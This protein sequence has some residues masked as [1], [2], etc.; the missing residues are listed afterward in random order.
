MPIVNCPLDRGAY[1]IIKGL[2]LYARAFIEYGA[3]Y[4]VRMIALLLLAIIIGLMGLLTPYF[5]KVL[6]DTV[7]TTKNH[8][9]LNKILLGMIVVIVLG[10]AIGLLRTYLSSVLIHKIGFDIKYAFYR[11]LQD[12]SVLFYGKKRVGDLMYRM[13][14]D[15]QIV[16]GSIASTPVSSLINLITATIVIIWMLYLNT[17]LSLFVFGVFVL[18]TIIIFKF[19]KPIR[20]LTRKSREQEEDIYGTAEEKLD[21]IQLVQSSG[22]KKGELH[23]FHSKLHKFIKISI[24][25]S[26]V[27]GLSSIST[28]TVATIWSFGVLWYGGHSVI[29]GDLT[30]GELMAF[31]V[32]CNMLFPTITSITTTIIELP[33]MM[34]SLFRF[35]EIKDHVPA[36]QELKSAPKASITKGGISFKHVSFRYPNQQKFLLKDISLEIA[37]KEKVALVG[38]SGAGKTTLVN[39]IPRFLDP[40]EGEITVDGY[41]V[42]QIQIRSLRDGIGFVLQNFFVFSGTIMD[43]IRYGNPRANFDEVEQAAKMANVHGHIISLPQGYNTEVGEKGVQLSSG[44]AQRVALARVILKDPKILILDEATSFLDMQTES[45]IQKAITNVSK[46]RTTIVIAHRLT[47]AKQA[48]RILFLENGEI[49]ESGTHQELIEQHGLYSKFWKLMLGV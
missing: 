30:I 15:T 7:V 14:R 38:R 41:D 29:K 46:D 11:H 19:Q 35:Y 20:E 5:T 3:K 42:K 24:R 26:L 27:S 13:F 34:V 23:R 25:N 28:T 40:I 31:M 2:K 47:T 21:G 16:C 43:N 22:A 12:L 39:L 48:D 32:L 17:S 6:L 49:A 18:H 44:E 9:L 37:P 8:A 10:S 33:S 36:I 1:V 4:K 45:L